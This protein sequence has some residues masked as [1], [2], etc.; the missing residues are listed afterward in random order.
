MNEN[1]ESGTFS[2]IFSSLTKPDNK[3]FFGALQFGKKNDS[4]QDIEKNSQKQS[5]MNTKNAD[6]NSGLL[7]NYFNKLKTEVVKSAIS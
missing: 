3:G 2:S 6:E 4:K 7:K 5:E 1:K